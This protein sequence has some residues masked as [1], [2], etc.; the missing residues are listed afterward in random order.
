MDSNK[1]PVFAFGFEFAVGFSEALDPGIG[2]LQ[3]NYVKETKQGTLTESV[4]FVPCD[5][6]SAFFLKD[7][8]T[9][10]KMMCLQ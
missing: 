10:L 1:L 9:P 3:I 7:S 6:D 8:R 2:T 4:D 5:S